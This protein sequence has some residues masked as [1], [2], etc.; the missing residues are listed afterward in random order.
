MTNHFAAFVLFEIKSKNRPHHISN[1]NDILMN[2]NILNAC[3]YSH[4]MQLREFDVVSWFD[5]HWI[6]N[7]LLINSCN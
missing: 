2:L 3:A 6:Q 7:H 1:N 5:V 4:S